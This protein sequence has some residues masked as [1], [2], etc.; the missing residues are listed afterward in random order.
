MSSEGEQSTF[1]TPSPPS[2]GSCG[3]KSLMLTWNL[4]RSVSLS[5]STYTVL[6]SDDSLLGEGG[7]VYFL[8]FVGFLTATLAFS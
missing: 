1:A 7:W 4:F 8:C 6:G 2:W 5:F 3:K